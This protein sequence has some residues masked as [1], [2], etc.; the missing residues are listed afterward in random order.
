MDSLASF[1]SSARFP[2]H[3]MTDPLTPV[4]IEYR[5]L[6]FRVFR[7]VMLL[8]LGPVALQVIFYYASAPPLLLS[9]GMAAM[10]LGVIA[11]ALYVWRVWACPA[12]GFKLWVSDGSGTLGGQ[13]IGC[14]T[15]LYVPIR[16][17]SGRIFP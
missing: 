15:Q 3:E 16:S 14:K 5:R 4:Q 6:R 2:A 9:L 17:K 8:A 1:I 11:S 13:C 12:C 7:T 10:M